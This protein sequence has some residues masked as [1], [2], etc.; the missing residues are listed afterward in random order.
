MLYTCIHAMHF[1]V[2]FHRI[3]G[4]IFRQTH[5]RVWM[6]SA[7]TREKELIMMGGSLLWWPIPKKN[8]APTP[9]IAT[10]GPKQVPPRRCRGP[11]G[12]NWIWAKPPQLFQTAPKA[13]LV[14]PWPAAFSESRGL[15]EGECAK[16]SLDLRCPKISKGL[17][18]AGN[19]SGISHQAP[20]GQWC[21]QDMP[22]R[23]WDEFNTFSGEPTVVLQLLAKLVTL[24]SHS[25][26]R[27]STWNECAKTIDTSGQTV[28]ISRKVSTSV[29]NWWQGLFQKMDPRG[30]VYNMCV[31]VCGYL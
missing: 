27:Y 14:Y 25:R 29:A 24:V 11:L 12:R 26:K 15:E 28:K 17:L 1:Q 16:V 19:N 20:N 6:S 3:C 13:S 18:V 30:T 10:S 9:F 23:N 2:A 5:A 31:C 22:V 21:S 7:Y 8:H 4:A